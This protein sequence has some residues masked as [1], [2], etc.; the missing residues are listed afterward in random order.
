M[1]INAPLNEKVLFAFRRIFKFGFTKQIIYCCQYVCTLFMLLWF[2]CLS[3][4][5]TTHSK[6]TN[7]FLFIQVAKYHQMIEKKAGLSVCGH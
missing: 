4:L 1:K 2:F 7:P 6:I 3:F 5:E